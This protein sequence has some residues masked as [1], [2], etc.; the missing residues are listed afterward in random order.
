MIVSPDRPECLRWYSAMYYTQRRE[1]CLTEAIE[2]VMG[3]WE[4]EI[5]FAVSKEAVTAIYAAQ[6]RF[7]LGHLDDIDL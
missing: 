2:S 6:V 4:H 3:D 5:V 7:N 1:I